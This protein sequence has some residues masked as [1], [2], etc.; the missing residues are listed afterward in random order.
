VASNENKTLVAAIL[1]PDPSSPSREH[2]WNYRAI[3]GMLTFLGTFTRPD[4]AFAVHQC[5]HFSV[6]PKRVHE[7]TVYCI[8]CYLKGTKTKGLI[9]RPSPPTHTLDCYVD[10]D[11]AGLWTP[12]TSHSPMSVKSCTSHIIT[13]L[14]FPFSG[15]PSSK[16]R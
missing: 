6:A 8:V 13:L 4:I 5:A 9:L 11:F 15:L 3:I 10:A 1:H 16:L 14:L 2:S 12:N 7:V